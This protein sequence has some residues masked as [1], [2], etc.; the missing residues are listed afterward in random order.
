MKL[1]LY[2]ILLV[3]YLIWFLYL[4]LIVVIAVFVNPLERLKVIQ[5]SSLIVDV[6][7]N[8]TM[9]LLFCPWWSD[10]YFQFKS[11]INELSR[12]SF[13]LEDHARLKT[14]GSSSTCS[15]YD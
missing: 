3:F 10:W 1:V 2:R 14:Y 4:P 5:T 11:E 7:A 9:I 6:L 13:R 12:I 15:E 8:G